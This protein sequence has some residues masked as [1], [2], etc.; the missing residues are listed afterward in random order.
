M[1]IFVILIIILGIGIFVFRYLTSLLEVVLIPNST[2]IEFCTVSFTAEVC[3]SAVIL[4]ILEPT[5]KGACTLKAFNSRSSV[6][7]IA[8]RY[9]VLSC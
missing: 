5:T 8:D 6:A 4:D 1:L 2:L 9:S 7:F 3:S